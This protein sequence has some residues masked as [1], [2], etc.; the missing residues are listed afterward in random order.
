MLKKIR[1]TRIFSLEIAHA[2]L[3]CNSLCKNLHGH[4]YK[5]EVTVIGTPDN[6][7]SKNGMVIDFNVLNEIIDSKIIRVFDHSLI[8]NIEHF[9]GDFKFFP[10]MFERVVLV[11]YQPTCENMLFD[12]AERIKNSLPDGVELY[13]LRLRET[14]RSFAEWYSIDNW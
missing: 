13:S 14:D 11:P 1:I 10:K 9:N 12:F 5:L 2:L 8:W 3:N 7:N 6:N 4:S